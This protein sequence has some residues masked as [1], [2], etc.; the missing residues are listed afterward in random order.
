MSLSDK[1]FKT[2]QELSEQK[3]TSKVDQRSITLSGL[4]YPTVASLQDEPEV[5]SLYLHIYTR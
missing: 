5:Q 4:N 2:L 3:E 1:A